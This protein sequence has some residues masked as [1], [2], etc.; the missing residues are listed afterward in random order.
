MKEFMR[1]IAT[2]CVSF[3]FSCIFYLFFSL[4]TIFPPLD[5]QTGHLYVVYFNWHYVI[6]LLDSSITYSKFICF[7]TIGDLSLSSSFC[8]WQAIFQYGSIPEY[9]YSR[10]SSNWIIDVYYRDYRP[11][12]WGPSRCAAN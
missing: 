7:A 1:Y 9:I 10:C 4:L 8:L 3:T 5:E 2:G 6:D 12:Y 11:I